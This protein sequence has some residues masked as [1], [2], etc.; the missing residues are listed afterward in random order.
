[1]IST[2]TEENYT[3]V[4]YQLASG[5]EWI[6]TKELAENMGIRPSSV[7]DMMQKLDSKG[8]VSY[9]KYKGV[10]LT[11]DG[12]KLALDII[13]KHRLW[14]VFLYRKLGFSWDEVHDIA[15]QLEHISSSELVRRLDQYLDFPR[16]DPHGDP[17]PD[18]KGKIKRPKRKLLSDCVEGNQGQLVGV[19]DSSVDF[20]RFLEDRKLTLGIGLEVRSVHH[21]D[22]SM[23]LVLVDSGKVLNVSDRVTKNLYINTENT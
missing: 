10:K 16:L 23:D 7:T 6:N 1:M 11:S 20:L 18:D 19:K 12:E 22:S 9:R 14:E 5:K 2:Q 15:E 4:I 3:K 17:I 13:R 8:V 21:F